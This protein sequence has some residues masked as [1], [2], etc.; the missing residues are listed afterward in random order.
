MEHI[1]LMSIPDILPCLI[2]NLKKLIFSVYICA[3]EATF[4]KE[5]CGLNFSRDWWS[6][7]SPS[8]DHL[9][10]NVYCLSHEEERWRKLPPWWTE[11]HKLLIYEGTRQRI[12]CMMRHK[13]NICSSSLST[14]Y[15]I[16]DFHAKIIFSLIFQLAC[17]DQCSEQIVSFF[18]C[19]YFK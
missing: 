16:F 2:G 7:C 1:A 19:V 13:I 12:L 5:T 9:V 11:V 17:V 4:L 8:T 6:S 15:L 3:F 10:G 14:D 18:I